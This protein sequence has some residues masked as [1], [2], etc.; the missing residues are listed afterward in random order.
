MIRTKTTFIL[1]AGASAELHM[2]G[3]VEVLERIAQ[4]LDFSRTGA[5]QLT[6]DTAAILRHITKLAERMNRTEDA[7][8]RAGQR[9]HQ[10]AKIGRT[11]EQVIEQNNDDPLVEAF[12]KLAIAVFT[13]QAESRSSLRATPQP[14]AALPLQTGDYWL[15]ELGKLLTAG[16]PRS[17]VEAGLGDISIVSFNYDRSVEH[18]LHFALATAYG[19]SAAI[20]LLKRKTGNERD[21]RLMICEGRCL[22]VLKDYS[23]MLET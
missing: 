12:G 21:D 22:D 4:A 9:I 5:N 15:I 17:K 13:L 10:A 19:M 8:Y 2:P 23:L 11:I 14:N 7:L 1:G 18:F 16:L 6:R 3:P 20:R